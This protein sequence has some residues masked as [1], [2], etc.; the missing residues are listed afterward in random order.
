M[1]DLRST[2]LCHHG[3]LRRTLTCF[4]RFLLKK[5]KYLLRRF[6]CMSDF[7]LFKKRYFAVVRAIA[8]DKDA[9]EFLE[10]IEKKSIEFYNVR[11]D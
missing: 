10:D 8:D 3:M 7:A 2:R 1:T 4:I 11:T 6:Y 5:F 9:Q